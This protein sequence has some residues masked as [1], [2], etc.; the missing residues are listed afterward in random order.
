MQQ[1]LTGSG[2]LILTDPQRAYDHAREARMIADLL[3]A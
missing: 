3:G 2:A 1:T